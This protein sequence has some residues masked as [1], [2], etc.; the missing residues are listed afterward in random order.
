MSH[1]VLQAARFQKYQ[2]DQ[3]EKTQKQK[4]LENLSIKSLNSF[5]KSYNKQHG[6]S[7]PNIENLSDHLMDDNKTLKFHSHCI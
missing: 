5:L 2:L 3:N 7:F 1:L 6:F 4:H